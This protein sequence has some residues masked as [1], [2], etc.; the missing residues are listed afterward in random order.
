MR[1]DPGREPKEHI[2]ERVKKAQIRQCE[3]NLHNNKRLMPVFFEQQR[4]H[5][6]DKEKSVCTRFF[7]IIVKHDNKKLSQF[8]R[9]DVR[10]GHHHINR[11]IGFY[12]I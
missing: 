9:I 8:K 11:L 2:R 6:Q 5:G 12:R 10:K 4:R 1:I 7:R 3:C